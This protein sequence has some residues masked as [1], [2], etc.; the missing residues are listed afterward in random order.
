[1]MVEVLSVFDQYFQLIMD[2]LGIALWEV[3]WVSVVKRSLYF[4]T[5]PQPHP[6][7]HTYEINCCNSDVTDLDCKEKIAIKGP[8]SQ[9]LFLSTSL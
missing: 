7:P 6:F 8:E 2:L 3:G 5:L 1:M 9:A 4:L